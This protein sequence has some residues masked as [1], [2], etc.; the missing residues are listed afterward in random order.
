MYI[1]IAE[2]MCEGGSDSSPSLIGK[3]L[4]STCTTVV[5]SDALIVRCPCGYNEV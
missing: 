5:D 3:P 2:V 1:I 4:R